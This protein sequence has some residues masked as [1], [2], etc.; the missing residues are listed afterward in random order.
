MYITIKTLPA[1]SI[2]KKLHNLNKPNYIRERY[3]DLINRLYDATECGNGAQRFYHANDSV[4]DTPDHS[5]PIHFTLGI[6][7]TDIWVQRRVSLSNLSRRAKWISLTVLVFPFISF[8]MPVL[9]ILP[10]RRGRRVL[11]SSKN[12]SQNYS[13]LHFC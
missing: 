10:V 13:Q 8:E 7:L 2:Q 5:L 3:F 4:G 11:P 1:I 12:K 9:N 6:T